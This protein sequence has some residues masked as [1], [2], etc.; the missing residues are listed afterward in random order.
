MR[1]DDLLQNLKDNLNGRPGQPIVLGVCLA[2]ARRLD[3]EPWLIRAAAIVLGVLFTMPT[4][5]AYVLAGLLLE[6]TAD[7][8][9]GAFQGLL[10]T[11]REVTEKIIQAGRELFTGPR[12]PR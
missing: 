8:T 5:L 3:Q 1:N 9:R 12:Q 7:R 6:E 10:V 4:L 2:L 11:L